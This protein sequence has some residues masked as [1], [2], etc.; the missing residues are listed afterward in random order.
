MLNTLGHMAIMI[1]VIKLL[2]RT[3]MKLQFLGRPNSVIVTVPTAMSWGSVEGKGR[4]TLVDLSM[5]R[6]L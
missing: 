4:D 1:V 5:R 3:D 2:T 6:L